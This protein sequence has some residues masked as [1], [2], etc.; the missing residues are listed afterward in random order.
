MKAAINTLAT[1]TIFQNTLDQVAV[2]DATTGWM[3]E[4]AGTTGQ[5]RRIEA[6]QIVLEKRVHIENIY[7][8]LPKIHYKYI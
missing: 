3:D 2:Q 6:G 8:I 5:K 4:N 7:T 1:A